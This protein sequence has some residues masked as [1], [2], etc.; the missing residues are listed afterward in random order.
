VLWKTSVYYIFWVCVCSLSHP[1]CI[2]LTPYYIIPFC[3]TGCTI[4]FHIISKTIQFSRKKSWNVKCE[5]WLS[6]ELLS[7]AFLILRRIQPDTVINVHTSPSKV[8]V[9][10]CLILITLKLSWQIFKNSSIIK[11]HENPSIASQIFPCSRQ[12]D[13]TKITV[14]FCNFVNAPKNVSLE[15]F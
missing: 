8:P 1:A 15:Y 12:T 2:V 10:F 13:R 3:L 7:K 11:F 6:L 5:F 14:A 9:N 4:F